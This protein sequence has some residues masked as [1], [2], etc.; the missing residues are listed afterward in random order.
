MGSFIE[1]IEIRLI[2]VIFFHA[3]C[4]HSCRK[5]QNP[6]ER[7]YSPL[8]LSNSFLIHLYC[9]VPTHFRAI[10]WSELH[11][12]PP[13]LQTPLSLSLITTFILVL[14][15]FYSHHIVLYLWQSLSPLNSLKLYEYLMNSSRVYDIVQQTLRI[16]RINEWMSQILFHYLPWNYKKP[17]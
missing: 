1:C 10:F 17:P 5:F 2:V 16:C 6:R 9:T 3:N 14:S 8:E 7:P 13:K 11:P 12:S 4:C 15:Q